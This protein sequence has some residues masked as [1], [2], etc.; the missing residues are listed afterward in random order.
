LGAALAAQAAPGRC[1]IVDCLALWL[2]NL[3]MAGDEAQF[4]AERQAL[5][6]ALPQLPGEIILVGNETNMG[7]VPMGA[8]SRRW[9]D[10]AGLLHQEAA[11]CCERVVLTIAGL[12]QTLKGDPL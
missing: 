11:R 10:E 8:L 7:V 2:T 4:L 6:D 5:L 3:L 9:C 12:P 1:L